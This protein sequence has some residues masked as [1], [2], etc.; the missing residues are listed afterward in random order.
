M[1]QTN[2]HASTS[3]GVGREAV[4]AWEDIITM[5]EALDVALRFGKKLKAPSPE[6]AQQLIACAQ[7]CLAR[8]QVDENKRHH[9]A[10]ESIGESVVAA[11][12]VLVQATAGSKGPTAGE[13]HVDRATGCTE[14]ALEMLGATEHALGVAND[15]AN[16]RL[17]LLVQATGLLRGV[18]EGS[19]VSEEGAVTH[20]YLRE[21]K[22]FLESRI[23]PAS[24]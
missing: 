4:N 5:T 11:I 18:A 10:L 1:E 9:D 20:A 23:A 7:L 17:A 16:K 21:I 13:L 8:M 2:G 12:G 14:E 24:P 3:T 6:A 22:Q 15:L 19:Q